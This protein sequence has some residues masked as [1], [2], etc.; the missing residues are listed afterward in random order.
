MQDSPRAAALFPPPRFFASETL[1]I[2]E[3]MFR[4]RNPSDVAIYFA[5]QEEAPL[6]IVTWG[7]LRERVRQ[8]RSALQRSGVGRGDVVAAVISNSVHA[9]VLALATASLG[10]IWSSSSCDLGV[11]GIVD[12]Y[13]QIHPKVVFADEGYVYGSKTFDLKERIATWAKELL[14]EPESRLK[15]VV[16]IGQGHKQGE[17]VSSIPAGFRFSSFLARDGGDKLAFDLVPFTH[18]GFILFS[19]GTV[20]QVE[21]CVGAAC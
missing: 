13:R 8:A 15:D 21:V 2:A 17:D 9:T 11:H 20:R 19:S 10:A 3:I 5:C 1:S 7:E 12:R 4:N 14:A 16:V 6:E 18:P